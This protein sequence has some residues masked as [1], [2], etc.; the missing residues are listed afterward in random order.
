MA[1]K[2]GTLAGPRHFVA[3][4]KPEARAQDGITT[5][6]VACASGF[7]IRAKCSKRR[8]P[9]SWPLAVGIVLFSGF[10][11]MAKA[12]SINVSAGELRQLQ[13]MIATVIDEGFDRQIQQ[14]DENGLQAI[15]LYSDLVQSRNEMRR[16]ADRLLPDAL[17]RL[18]QLPSADEA[19]RQAYL[20]Q[21]R[22]QLRE[23]AAAL[24]VERQKVRRR[25]RYGQFAEEVRQ[26]IDLQAANYQR[27]RAIPTLS[28]REQTLG[29]VPLTETQRDIQVLCLKLIESLAEISMWQGAAGTAATE[30]LQV[31][32]AARVEVEAAAAVKQLV[33]LD[34]EPA[35]S[36]QRAVLTG[37]EAVMRKIAQDRELQLQAA[38]RAVESL[39]A[40]QQELQTETRDG[41]VTTPDA[42]PEATRDEPRDVT[43]SAQQARQAELVRQQA[44][45]R[46]DLELLDSALQQLPAAQPHWE[47]AKT[48]TQ[49]AAERL[50]SPR[51]ADSLPS[52]TLALSRMQEVRNQLATA[53]QGRDDRSAAQLA[54]RL[55]QL[56]QLHG[57][58]QAALDVQ[59]EAVEQWAGA[60]ADRARAPGS[61]TDPS[62]AAMQAAVATAQQAAAQLQQLAA[63]VAAIPVLAARF[64]RAA[65]AGARLAREMKSVVDG[66][67]TPAGGDVAL[68]PTGDDDAAAAALAAASRQAEQTLRRAGAE[69]QSQQQ[70]TH[71]RALAVKIGEVA[72]AAEILE[73]AAAT[74]QRLAE[75]AAQATAAG[76][77]LDAATRQQIAQE[78]GK[79]QQ[80]ARKVREALQ[81]VTRAADSPFAKADTAMAELEQLLRRPVDLPE[82][83][84]ADWIAQAARTAAK[85]LAQAARL[86]RVNVGVTAK[87]L[88]RVA[89]TQLSVAAQ[90]LQSVAELDQQTPPI[91]AAHDVRSV[92]SRVEQAM[93]AQLLAMGHREAARAMATVFQLDQLRELRQ[94][95][96]LAERQAAAGRA[97]TWLD[98]AL[99][100]QSWADAAGKL[101]EVADADLAERLRQTATHA[102]NVAQQLLANNR[103]LAARYR[104]RATEQLNG[105]TELARKQVTQAMRLAAEPPALRPQLEVVAQLTAAL[106]SLT[107]GESL[108]AELGELQAQASRI[109]VSLEAPTHEQQADPLRAAQIEVQR[110]L[111]KVRQ[112]LHRMLDSELGSWTAQMRAHGQ[113]TAQTADNI[114]EVSPEAAASV[115]NA[116]REAAAVDQPSAASG[117]E[118]AAHVRQDLQQAEETL[119]ALMQ[120]IAADKAIAEAVAELMEQQQAARDRI[121]ELASQLTGDDNP[122]GGEE[123][124]DAGT[125]GGAGESLGE[126]PGDSAGD[127]AGDAGAA[128]G[129]N[130]SGGGG[131][132]GDKQGR[133]EGGEG[134]G[135]GN[136][137][138]GSSGSGGDGGADEGSAEH[139][140]GN[141]QEGSLASELGAATRDFADAQRA[142]G[143][144]AQ[145]ISDQQQI[146]NDALAEALKFASELAACEDYRAGVGQ[147]A[148]DQTNG[149]S[150]RGA[151]ASA[152]A[153][154]MEAADQNMGSDFVPATPET[155][156]QA[157][158]GPAALEA[159]RQAGGSAGSDGSR[160]GDEREAHEGGSEAAK[161]AGDS[162]PQPDQLAAGAA[163]EEPADDQSQ[164]GH[165]S[166]TDATDRQHDRPGSADAPRK[167]PW[168][169]AAGGGGTGSQAADN[170]SRKKSSPSGKEFSES[171]FAELP[172]T[173]REA[174]RAKA[175]RPP[176]RGYENKLRRYFEQ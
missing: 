107:H 20:G 111:E 40:R 104:Q 62:R 114:Q 143:E 56:R 175:T 139:R 128:T 33:R 95:A 79:T 136:G 119:T 78:N 53:I 77:N 55:E 125:G 42:T 102:N 43:A 84:P 70:Q 72:R 34:L 31:L 135:D 154:S 145:Q 15:S 37:L 159:A 18:G 118:A 120:Q 105:A 124:D 73:R 160:A 21:T 69:I 38:L 153:N 81:G 13:Q 12:D 80:V 96:A 161:D 23:V 35:L 133:G 109:A 63:D 126:R 174:I 106:E 44:A 173:L 137:A 3:R 140:S 82:A 157:I 36:A 121:A 7:N 41:V 47:D 99:A 116:A 22:Q 169:A 86:L 2:H 68:P 144:G 64:A 155:T 151:D 138:G 10:C 168:D 127:G 93:V 164:A 163:G 39:I 141:G 83:A 58:Q 75:A 6:T 50:R 11:S 1:V 103:E 146:A 30:G 87:Q 112:Q 60:L 88:S 129:E 110:R 134:N 176:P 97:T 162:A 49:S 14:L 51:P 113:Q 92:L 48:A 54:E 123:G 66:Q 16:I 85:Q 98:A 147:A 150:R 32:R 4:G 171:W 158:A 74:Q 142:T 90:S 117:A 76:T 8:F 24:L 108:L 19:A 165:E 67:T 89:E 65:D 91:A 148:G 46:A 166:A 130:S 172:A 57:R 167:T 26:L 122:G 100:H 94:A 17:L 131:G 156:A 61:A 59:R 29:M 52:Q 9:T 115:D 5:K 170:P 28:N 71:R 101:S 149:G 25:L 27:T 132:G 152:P 45:L